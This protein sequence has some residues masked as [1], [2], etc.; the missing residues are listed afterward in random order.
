MS[1]NA[2]DD[3][4]TER[5]VWDLPVR[6]CH[7]LLVFA[8]AGAYVTHRLGLEYFNWHVRF[9]YTVIVLVS[10]RLL[11][12]F[13]GTYHARFLNFVRHPVTTLRYALVL[14]K[15]SHH[16]FAGHNPLGA[17]MVV[18]LLLTLWTQAATGLF[19][20]DDI[21][22]TGPL[23]GHV[24]IEQSATLTS[25]H[26]ALFYWIAAAIGLHIAAVLLHRVLH[27]ENLVSAMF[28]GRKPDTVVPP[29]EAIES[30]RL[31]LALLLV[32]GLVVLLRWLVVTA[33]VAEMAFY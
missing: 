20:S 30:S 9:G 14:L 10:F 13:V 29:R 31:W 26:R 5:L 7:W 24:T 11:W 28:H 18:V 6:L 15:G 8:V 25:L 2:R 23:Y 12:G 1:E 17:W 16:P 21:A 32:T 4:P 27:G 3:S 33:P 22:N 19:A